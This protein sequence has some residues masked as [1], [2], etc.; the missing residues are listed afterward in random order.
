MAVIFELTR[1]PELLSQYYELREKC[2]RVELGLP[3]FDGSE[4]MQ[5]KLGQ[6]LIA[7]QDG[8]V[9]AGARISSS[10]ALPEHILD[11]DLSSHNSCMWE[12]LVIN[13]VVR[14]VDFSRD[15]CGSLVEMSRALGYR[16]A[17][18][19]SSMRNARHYRR[20]HT[21]LDVQFQIRKAV[22][23]CAKGKFAGLEHYLSVAHLQE[24]QSIS[25]AA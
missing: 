20:C 12:R 2:F 14:S 8:V 3:E 18:I 6:I 23:D 19:L 13:P 4:D 11:G 16:H 5:D 7:H 22:P 10:W 24:Q 1:D 9:L 21:A 17:L 25:M 15:F